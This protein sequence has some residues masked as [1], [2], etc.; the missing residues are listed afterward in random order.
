MTAGFVINANYSWSH[1]LDEI[2]NGGLLNYGANT[3]IQT[4]INPACFRCNNYGN[5]DYD[6]RHSFNANWVWTEPFHFGNPIL[7]AILGGWMQSENFIVRSGIPYTVTDG[8]VSTSNGGTAPVTQVIGQGQGSC[9][10]GLSACINSAAFLAG[11]QRSG[12][13][14]FFPTQTPQPVPWTGIL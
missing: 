6:I 10:S 1:T 14:G 9:S 3:D 5:A 8:S 11:L 4:Q 12:N 7:N 13:L 2:S